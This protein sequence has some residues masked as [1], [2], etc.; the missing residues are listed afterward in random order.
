MF[1]EYCFVLEVSYYNNNDE[2]IIDIFRVVVNR[3]V[4]I[5]VSLL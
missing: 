1:V 4:N 3:I 5:G 2:F